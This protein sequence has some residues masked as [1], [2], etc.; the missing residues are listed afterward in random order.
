MALQHAAA[1]DG[2]GER[3]CEAPEPRPLTIKAEGR[4]E[5]IQSA[6]HTFSAMPEFIAPDYGRDAEFTVAGQGLGIDDK[7]RLASGAQHIVAVQVLVKENLPPLAV[8]DEC[9]RLQR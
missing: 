3:L 6:D 2:P 4:R 7:P 1:L 9:K 5:P 8:A